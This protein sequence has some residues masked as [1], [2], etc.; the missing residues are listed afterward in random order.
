[1]A[2]VCFCFSFRQRHCAVQSQAQRW[3]WNSMFSLR[4]IE[5][6]LGLGHLKSDG[7]GFI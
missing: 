2:K 3:N 1:M 4:C 5:I 7:V 6:K